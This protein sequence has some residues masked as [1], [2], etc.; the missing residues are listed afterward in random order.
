MRVEYMLDPGCADTQGIGPIPMRIIVV[1][2]PLSGRGKAEREAVKVRALL[3]Q[4]GHDVTRLGLSPSM[5]EDELP[6]RLREAEALV[7]VGGDGT[8]QACAEAAARAHT[9]LYHWPVGTEN[10]FA[11]EFGM[12]RDGRVLLAALDSMRSTEADLALCDG[13]LFVLMCSVG[14][15]A[16]IVHRLARVRT[17]AIT[18]MSYAR[19]VVMELLSPVLTPITVRVDGE[20]VVTD[21]PGMVFVAN[22]RQ[23]ALRIDP[24]KDASMTDGL[25]DVVHF[26]VTT[27]LG[28]LKWMGLSRL[29]RQQAVRGAVIARGSRVEVENHGSAVPY[30]LDGEAEGMLG[31]PRMGDT[32]ASPMIEI[33]LSGHKLRVLT[34]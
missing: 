5:V 32:G 4:R 11:R 27:R 26:P 29:R 34:G 20:A 7:V 2:N 8:V 10:L 12:K 16:S 14:P 25:L 28:M 31:M 1:A 15:D 19:H 18:K 22:S 21:R 3:L 30:Q 13:R 24:A 23:Y 6:G 33:G 17:G 9:P